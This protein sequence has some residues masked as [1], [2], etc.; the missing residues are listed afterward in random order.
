MDTPEQIA[1][2]VPVTISG[3]DRAA[4]LK[5]LKDQIPMYA[6]DGVMPADGAEK[7]WQ[8]LAEFNPKFRDVK[9]ADTYTNAFV[10]KA[11]QRQ[12]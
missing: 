9:V 12:P 5:I 6:N 8:V 3:K 1:A 11:L 2:V 4:Y 7:E 10:E